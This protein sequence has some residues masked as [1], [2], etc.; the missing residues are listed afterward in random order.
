MRPGRQNIFG[1]RPAVPMDHQLKT[2]CQQRLE[3]RLERFRCRASGT[4]GN[5]IES[6]RIQPVRATD[7]LIGI[8]PEALPI[9]ST[10]VALRTSYRSPRMNPPR[11]VGAVD[12]GLTWTSAASNTGWLSGIRSMPMRSGTDERAS[13][14]AHL[15]SSFRESRY[16]HSR[17]SITR[18]SD[19]R[20]PDVINSDKPAAIIQSL[21]SQPGIAIV[22]TRRSRGIRRQ[23][24]L[25][26]PR[27][28]IRPST[29][30]RKHPSYR[31]R[32][33]GEDPADR[34]KAGPGNNAEP[35]AESSTFL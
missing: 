7:D 11:V 24:R 5:D 31:S 34:A 16:Q 17:E 8:D 4:Y 22:N 20:T 6:V 10:M 32:M 35:T 21:A 3:H 9:R 19:A 1:K 30:D 12:V 14:P 33:R 27:R 2:L 15:H 26:H 23:R 13:C 25:A 18:T 28:P 29:V